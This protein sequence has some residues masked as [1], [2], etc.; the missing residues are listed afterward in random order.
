M[1]NVTFNWSIPAT[2]N[3]IITQYNLTVVN[4]DTPNTTS[5]IIDVT[6]DQQ[7]V[8]QLVSG[9]RPYENYT[10]TV[11]GT[12]LV[13]YGPVAVTEGPDSKLLYYIEIF[14]LFHI[15]SSQ[16]ILVTVPIELAGA[17]FITVPVVNDTAINITWTPPTYPNG[18]ISSYTIVIRSTGLVRH[19]IQTM[20]NIMIYTEIIN[21]LG[22]FLYIYMTNWF[23]SESG[24]PYYISIT[25]TNEFGVGKV[26]TATVFTKSESK[27]LYLTL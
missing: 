27:L 3:G 19:T 15:A 5:Y 8:S 11:T 14:L 13:G 24:V 1:T 9:F 10:A 7:Q 18:F 25:A 6:A 22:K 12:T 21:G 17:T 4:L 26:S 2:P 23:I 20:P 16:P